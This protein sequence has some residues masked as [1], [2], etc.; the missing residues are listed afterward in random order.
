MIPGLIEPESAWAWPLGT[1]GGG[2]KNNGLF[3]VPE[4]GDEVAV[5]FKQGK[6]SATYYLSAHWGK[7][8]GENEAPKEAQLSSPDNRVFSTNT[9]CIELNESEGN[10]KLKLT[11]RKTGDHL[12][13]DAEENTVTIEGT[14]AL[15]LKAVGAISLEATQITIGGRVVRPIADPI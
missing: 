1:C 11:N 6:V 15:T 7:P 4:I 13:F 14:T 10:R 5:F 12:T 2:F 3:A 8:A 9:F